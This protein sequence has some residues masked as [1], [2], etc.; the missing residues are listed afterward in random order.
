MVT[1]II[2][3]CD[4]R[5]L[6]SVVVI[7]LCVVLLPICCSIHDDK[8]REEKKKRDPIQLLEKHVLHCGSRII[9]YM[10]IAVSYIHVDGNCVNTAFPTIYI[11]IQGN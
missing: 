5:R 6:C 2:H 8:W 10:Y 9:P 4:S 3:I 1:S 7:H 11:Y